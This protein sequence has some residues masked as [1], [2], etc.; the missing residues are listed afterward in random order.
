MKTDWDLAKIVGL[1]CFFVGFFVGVTSMVL[2]MI[3]GL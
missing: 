3:I 1:L 2:A